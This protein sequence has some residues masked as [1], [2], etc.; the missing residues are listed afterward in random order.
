MKNIL[1]VAAVVVMLITT[2]L[3]QSETQASS[4]DQIKAKLVQWEESFNKRNLTNFGSF[5][6]ED[7]VGLYPNQPDQTYASTLNEYDRLFQNKFLAIKLEYDILEIEAGNDFGF[8]RIVET[9]EV[10][11][12]FATKSQY[13]Q[14]TGL[15]VW[16]KEKD[17]GWK[18]YRSSL[19][20]LVKEK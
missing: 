1:I 2:A 16:K 12:K 10:K 14:D 5:Y 20:P 6:A 3:A 19:F 9:S 18:I 15:L 17:G 8:T 11:P 13:A 7:Y 4:A